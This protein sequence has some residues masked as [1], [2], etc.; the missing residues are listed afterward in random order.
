MGSLHF[1]IVDVFAEEP[2]SGNQLA[3]FINTGSLTDRNRQ[4][5][6][7]E[8][9]YSEITFIESTELRDGGYDVRIYTPEKEVPFAGHPVLGTA[10]V[11]QRELVRSAVDRVT[12]NLKCGPIPVDFAYRGGEADILWMH[13]PAPSFGKRLDAPDVAGVLGIAQPEID[14][15][16]PIQ[17]ASTGFPFILIP[18][19]RLDSLKR[20]SV[21]LDLYYQLIERAEAKALLVFC[22]ETYSPENQLSVRVFADYYGTREDPAT[23]SANGALAAYLLN[24][25][26]FG[27][28]DVSARVEQGYEIARRSLLFLRAR[29]REG[30]ISVS[31]GGRVQPFA[32]SEVLCQF[33]GATTRYG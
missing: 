20:C 11:I 14:D 32:R 30:E 28:G 22:P 9:N 26:Y 25:R 23:G 16:F 7:R 31:V 19:R 3:V 8:M 2:L 21:N 12:L 1:Y 33:E 29:H 10:Y 15:R 4:Q 6:A 24:Y 5:L 27:E 17:E 13:Q 18:L